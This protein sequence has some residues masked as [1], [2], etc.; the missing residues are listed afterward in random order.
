MA[1][2]STPP[3]ADGDLDNPYAPPG[4]TFAPEVPPDQS[5]PI[6]FDVGD[7]FARA[8]FLYKTRFRHVMRL[9][10]GA[11]GVNYGINLLLTLLMQGGVAAFR[12]EISVKLVQIAAMFGSFVA[13]SF[14]GVGLTMVL[15]KVARRLEVG[16]EEV[17]RGG[18]HV[19]T[20]ILATILFGLSLAAPIFLGYLAIASLFLALGADLMIASVLASVPIA[21]VSVAV[22]IYLCTRLG[23]Y[24][25][26]VIDWNAG[27]L[28]SLQLSWQLTRNEVPTI[29]LVYMLWLT[30]YLTGS[31][32]LVVGLL[33]ALPLPGLLVLFIIGLVFVSPLANLLLIVTFQNLTAPE[34]AEEVAPVEGE[35]ANVLK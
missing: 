28:N 13:Q 1:P 12:D 3:P 31:L 2:S 4:S 24:Y 32:L 29:F 21:A 7:L 18:H 25:F 35:G 16:F 8:W 30:I 5:S 14:I 11:I 10:L 27:V 23:Q 9:T 6:P 34:G 17:F 19:L 22:S 26:V 33:L 20:V 15:F